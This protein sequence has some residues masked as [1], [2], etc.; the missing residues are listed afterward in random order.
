[1]EIQKADKIYYDT[2]VLSGGSSKGLITLGAIQYAL[3]NFLLKID[4]YVGTSSGAMIGY[5]LAIGYT[6]IDIMVFICVNQLMEKIQHFNIVS[7]I[8]G[9]GAASFTGLHEQMEKMTLSKIGYLPTLE[10]IYTKFGKILVCVTHNLSTRQ[11]EYLSYETHPH[12]PCLTAIRMSSNLPLVFDHYKYGGSFYIDGGISDNFAI[13]I[14]D[15]RGEKVLGIILE[16]ENGN[17]STEP[18]ISI[19]EYIYKLMFIPISQATEHKIKKVSDRCTI[20][21]L[22]YDSL[23]FFNFNVDSSTKLSM[24]SA[25]YSQMRDS[26][27]I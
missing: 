1:M 18:D 22:K 12:L 8:N 13:D 19:M 20:I 11:T 23:K 17:F 21:R 7:M 27:S 2:L 3:D 15:N 10:D 25:G 6:P 26:V 5:F 9:N 14:G 24:F 16:N 4:T